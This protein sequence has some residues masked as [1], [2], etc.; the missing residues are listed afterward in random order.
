MAQWRQIA[1]KLRDLMWRRHA[2]AEMSREIAAHIVLL[3][4]EFQ[5]RGMSVDDAR[6]EARKVCGGAEQAKQLHRDERS[7]L[8]LEQTAQDL[9]HACRSLARSPGFTLAVIATLA[10]GV[11]VNTTLFTAYNAVALKPLPVADAASVV[12]FQRFVASGSI[13]DNQYAFSWPEYA[14][15]RDHQSMFSAM[16]AASW[17]LRVLAAMPAEPGESSQT[18][19]LQG[20][21]VSGNYFSGLG[22]RAEVGRTF[23][24][25]EDTAPGGNPVI[26]L[27]DASWK[28]EFHG[29]ERAV[30]RIL[31]INGSAFTVIGVAQPEF[32]GT[33]L[34]PRIP[35]F[36]AP[37]SM[38]EQ[39][40][41]GQNWG[42]KPDDFQLQILAR[43]N[44]G[45]TSR[46]A[47]AE[48]TA[49]IG[50]FSKTYTVHDRT[51]TVKLQKTAFFGNTDDVRF[52][53]L[54]YALMAIFI[55]VLFVACANVT[56]MLLARGAARQREISVRL[57]LGAKRSRVIRHLLTESILLS[58]CGGASGLALAVLASKLIRVAVETMLVRY[59][60][61]DFVLSLNV[62]PDAR[63]FLYAF[64]LSLA[65]G[66]VFGLA[67]ALQFTRPD[68][69]TSLKDDRIS[70]GIRVG[71][72]R[73]R[74]VLV[75][76]QVA[77]S[78]LLLSS[79]GLLIRGLARSH[80]ADPGF[81]ASHLY[82]LR[83][84][85]GDDPAGAAARFHRLVDRLGASPEIE[86][87]TYGYGPMMG[88]WT[89]P[90][91]VPR[92][93]AK[94]GV[95]QA[96]TLASYAADNY[97]KTLG[98]SLLRGRD[99]T[100]HE[101]QTGARVSVIS[102]STAR[103][104]WPGEDPLGKHFQ[105]DMHF[106]GKLTEF[107]VIGIAKD[108]RLFSLTRI[109]PAHVYLATDPA[110]VGPILMTLKGDPQAAIGAMRKE[111]GS[112]DRNLLPSVSFWN[113]DTVLLGPQR[114]MA[115]VLAI[116]SAVLASLA[117]ALAGIGIYGVMAFVVSQ[118]TQEIGV[119]IALGATQRHI[120]T[121]VAA[122]GL[123]PVAFG[124]VAGLL[125]GGGLSL[126]LHRLT[127]VPDSPDILYGVRFYDPATFLAIT[128]F[129]L[130][131]A[132]AASLAPAIQAL[133]VNP[134]EALRYE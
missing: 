79:A 6:R 3:E 39:L 111:I 107:E 70:F 101:A 89:P 67:P 59:L 116:L 120:L 113:V 52:E 100:R 28:R 121:G 114:A 36:W 130:L 17:P 10:L 97:L 102:E 91:F 35:D 44:S 14:Y 103:R 81:D 21:L 96:R 55:L 19:T 133:K 72:S 53:A 16:M 7:I 105:L 128:L 85:F 32:T 15:C 12:R 80:A 4:D 115:R 18:Q 2:E 112:F 31:R 71:R 54:V 46:Q 126:F 87:L 90:I 123:R 74:S 25:D 5:R 69:T 78:M 26:V 38:Q 13:G 66:V 88:T 110:Y 125:S 60:G 99:I 131:I 48:V 23:G 76:V 61:S 82:M 43:L 24:M 58:L 64:G 50:Q 34:V 98:I 129:L 68:L 124:M 132:A 42:E 117:L 33:D 127:A 75:G 108:V 9:R 29:D 62:N 56:N 86:N 104:F 45:Y 22:I 73:L 118:R 30:G 49:L 109:D 134:T 1:A 11:G 92:P 57:A 93:D 8:W 27:S 37:L 84:D 119:R 77:V 94:Q 63:V 95:V 122:G 51:L 65:A 47:Q 41:P 83:A 40:A 106:T 20:Q